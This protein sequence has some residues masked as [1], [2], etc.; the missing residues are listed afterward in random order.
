MQAR[1]HG[2]P[3]LAPLARARGFRSKLKLAELVRTGKNDKSHRDSE[4]RSVS[5]PSSFWEKFECGPPRKLVCCTAVGFGRLETGT[6][7]ARL[8]CFFVQPVLAVFYKMTGRGRK[9]IIWLEHRRAF[10]EKKQALP[11]LLFYSAAYY[12]LRMLPSLFVDSAPV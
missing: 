9:E 10:W 1:S 5:E 4:S 3:C 6:A 8:G 11:L 7:L 2:R 12:R